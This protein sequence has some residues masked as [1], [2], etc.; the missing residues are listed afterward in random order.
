M[1]VQSGFRKHHSAYTALTNLFSDIIDSRYRGQYI[2]VQ[3][4]RSLVMLDYSFD[5]INE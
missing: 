2:F 3:F 1:K 4:R 5:M